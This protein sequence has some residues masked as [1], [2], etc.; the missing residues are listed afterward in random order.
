M[1]E[2]T[3]R[4]IESAPQI[5]SSQTNPRLTGNR[6]DSASRKRPRKVRNWTTPSTSRTQPTRRLNSRPPGRGIRGV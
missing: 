5:P 3:F 1:I 6:D 4:E 2:N